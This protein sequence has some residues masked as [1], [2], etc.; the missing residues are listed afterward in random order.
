MYLCVFNPFASTNNLIALK[1]ITNHK[2][3][4]KSIIQLFLK[5]LQ[6]KRIPKIRVSTNGNSVLRKLFD[7]STLN[8]SNV[9]SQ[10]ISCLC[11]RGSAVASSTPAQ[12]LKRFRA[13]KTYFS[14]LK[15]SLGFFLGLKGIMRKTGLSKQFLPQR[16]DAKPISGRMDLKERGQPC[17]SWRW[18]HIFAAHTLQICHRFR[19]PLSERKNLDQC[20]S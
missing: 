12:L 7:V 15:S 14:W 6:R 2:K 13:E 3:R 19:A 20:E 18:R 10:S 5:A 17:V 4:S 11:F 9:L 8:P 16:E 1:R